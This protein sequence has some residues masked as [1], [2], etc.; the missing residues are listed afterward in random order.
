MPIVFGILLLLFPVKNDR[1][2]NIINFIFVLINTAFSF[3]TFLYW[4]EE[5][6]SVVR[7]FGDFT[8]S[9]RIDRAACIFGVIVS[10]LWPFASLYAYGYMAHQERK[11]TFFSFFT[12]LTSI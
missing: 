11:N 8:I 6:I 5:S 2:R 9:F 7:L 12:I 3:M 1:A 10:G 4:K